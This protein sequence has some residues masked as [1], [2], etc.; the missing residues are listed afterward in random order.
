METFWFVIVAYSLALY[1][2]LDGF[3]LGAGVLHLF[4]AKTNEERRSVLNAIGP[5]WDG[6]EVWLLASG[7]IL[8]F[9]FPRVYASAFSG[10]Y[11]PLIIVLWLLMSRALGIELRHHVN[12]PMWQSF[13]DAA[14]GFGSMLLAVFFGAALGNVVRG[15]PLDSN[16]LFFLPLWTTFDVTGDPGVLDWFT[17]LMGLTAL[18]ILTMHGASYLL[19]KCEGAV[20]NRCRNLLKGRLWIMDIIMIISLIASIDVR[21]DFWEHYVNDVW[22]WI[23]PIGVL[24]GRLWMFVSLRREQAHRVFLGSCVMIGSA[25]GATAFAIFPRLLPHPTDPSLDL[26]VFN[27]AAP[28]YGLQVGVVWWSL[29]TVL[30]IGYFSYL[31]YSIR[32]KVK[33]DDHGY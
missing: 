13:W 12:H 10:F 32:G 19:M 4:V 8:Y 28:A 22:G 27:S 26:T 33:L 15:V 29:G 11:L 31:F 9:A 24:A 30:V 2:V 21:P 16:G 17:V 23:F 1:V 3:D 7:G 18:V 25:L 5:V 6:N 20:Y 14:F